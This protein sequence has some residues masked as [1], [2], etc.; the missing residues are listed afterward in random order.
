MVQWNR[1]Y[2]GCR[3]EGA[4]GDLVP[5]P[6]GNKRRVREKVIG[7]VIEA[8][9]EHKWKV[10]FDYNGKEKIVTSKSLKVVQIGAGLP[11]T[12]QSIETVSKG[13]ST[14]NYKNSFIILTYPILF[15]NL[16][17]TAGQDSDFD[18]T[19]INDA[20]VEEEDIENGQLDVDESSVVN[21]PNND[22]CFTEA[23][24][25][26]T[27]G[28]E[29]DEAARHR[30]NHSK[31]WEEIK[32]LEGE[33][34]LCGSG[35]DEIVWKVVEGCYVDE[36]TEKIKKEKVMFDR[37][38]MLMMDE[39]PTTFMECFMTMWPVDFWEDWT[40]LNGVIE[41]ENIERR[42]NYQKPIKKVYKFEYLRFLALLI[43]ASQYSKQ[44]TRLWK[45]SN[46]KN[47]EGFSETVDFS[48]YMKEWRF[49]Q[50]RQFI[51]R[52]MFDYGKKEE[53]D[54]WQ[55]STRVQNF[56]EVRQNNIKISCVRVLDE[57]MSAFI[58]R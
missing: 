3:V 58:P 33:E 44:G 52:V 20:A 47:L 26:N 51:P 14:L 13:K 31:A 28:T 40:R 1:I 8:A 34:F 23:D 55:F 21:A 35:D 19:L 22:F 27:T 15:F 45:S 17:S 24:L 11:M 30:M 37:G 49:K 54:W 4:H 9:G 39:M 46:Q 57:S 29:I 6:R 5:N 36:M 25:T 12:D 7:T 56:N 48:K 53:D 41:K 32:L 10:N 2:P 38:E 16:Q 50:L 42:K 43:A 18:P